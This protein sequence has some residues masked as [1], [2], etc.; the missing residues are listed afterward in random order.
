M[1]T[2]ETAMLQ[3]NVRKYIFEHFEE[4]AIAPVLADCS[5]P[6][7]AVARLAPILWR[8]AGGCNHVLS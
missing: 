7:K 6:K 4:T 3:K 2:S 8:T 1:L 5:D